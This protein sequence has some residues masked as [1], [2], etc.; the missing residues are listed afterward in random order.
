[1]EKASI[2]GLKLRKSGL[3]AIPSPAIPPANG[4]RHRLIQIVVKQH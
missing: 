2:A 4:F 3:F 1:M